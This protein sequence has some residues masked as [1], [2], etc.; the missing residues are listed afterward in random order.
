MTARLTI[1]VTANPDGR[2]R[3]LELLRTDA[4]A[5]PAEPGNAR[6]QVS[7]DILDPNRLVICESWKSREALDEHLAHDHTKAVLAAFE[8]PELIV[9]S[10]VWSAQ[11]D[12]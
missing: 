11:G 10:E 9:E 2:E 1:F 5:A 12:A 3:L 6:F 8:D 7:Q 4:A